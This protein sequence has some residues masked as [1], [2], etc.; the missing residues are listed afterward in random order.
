M[1]NHSSH[2]IRNLLLPCLAFS[3]IAGVLSTLA[4]TLFQIGAKYAVLLSQAVFGAVR[5]RPILLPGLLLAA[6]LV[7]LWLARVL[8]FCPTCRGGGI[9]TSIAAIQGIIPIRWI[10][11]IFVL[12]FAALLSFICGLPLGTEGPC[13]Q[14]GTGIGDVTVRLFGGK[15]HE[16]WRR[17]IMTG[18]AS[19]G[20]S[21]VTGAPIT[22]IV[23]SMEELHKR[24]SPLLFSVAAI[25]V[26]ASQLTAKL[27]SLLGAA[28]AGLFH[29]GPLAPLSV[30]LFFIP[31]LLGLLCGACSVLFTSLYHKIDNFMHTTLEKLPLSVKIPLLFACVALIGFFVAE[32][33]GSG[34]SLVEQ[35]FV[36]EL[37]WSLLIVVFLIR[38]VLMMIA[39]TA[40]VTGGIFLPT[41]A[42]GAILGSLSAEGFIALGVIGDEHYMLLV[43]LG[44]IAFL[45]ASSRIPLTACILAIEALSC[46]NNILPVVVAATAAFLIVELSGTK[47]FSDTVIERKEDALHRGKTAHAVKV[48]LTVRENAFVVGKDLRDVLWPVSCVVISVD[49]ITDNHDKLTISAGDVITVHYKTYD[50]IAVA[51]EF[52]ALV[53]DQPT[54]IDKIMRP[55]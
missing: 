35:L 36:R 46:G 34:H 9:P 7:G 48:P 40:G 53:G 30:A 38:A 42:F 21:L 50:P 29:V 10:T 22:A 54:E 19:A 43:I 1:K 31:L 39:N 27:L 5:E 51:E 47:D 17:Y 12:P 45:G 24:F 13:V 11:S 37:V 41:L 52:E 4:V 23:F 16:G 20:F 49:R 28:P 15:K 44:M 25:S 18:G 3:V 55:V 33:L 26:T 6:A 8:R 2:Y 14:M 32:I